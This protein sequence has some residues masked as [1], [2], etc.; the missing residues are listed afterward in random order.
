MDQTKPS[1]WS[2]RLGM[3]LTTPSSKNKP[4]TE[5]TTTITATIRGPIVDRTLWRN[6]VVVALSAN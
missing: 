3:G 2:S 4:V 1:T 5:T 6:I